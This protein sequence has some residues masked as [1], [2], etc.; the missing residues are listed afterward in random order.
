MNSSNKRSFGKI[1]LLGGILKYVFLGS[2]LDISTT[3]DR[4]QT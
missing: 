1:G 3:N 2:A 4:I